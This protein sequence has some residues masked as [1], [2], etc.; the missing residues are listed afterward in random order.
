MLEDLKQL[1]PAVGRLVPCT[2]I[3]LS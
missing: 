2:E 3:L 1:Q